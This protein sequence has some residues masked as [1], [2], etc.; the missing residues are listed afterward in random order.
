M[1]KKILVLG[2]G[3]ILF[4]DE[5][6]GVRVVE[7]MQSECT[8]SSNV[9][10]MDGGTLGTKLLD[11]F[12]HCDFLIIVDAVLGP[13]KPGSV[14]RLTGEDLRRSLAFKNS[15]HQTD[16]EDTLLYCELIAKRPDTVVIGVEPADMETA[17]ME[18]SPALNSAMRE[19]VNKTIKEIQACG[20]E[21]NFKKEA[22]F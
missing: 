19:I 11:Y 2:A 7:K 16:L 20:G 14:Y 22:V 18:L 9:T 3:N 13:G 5:G 1:E 10:L 6:V 15:L 12:I 21:C 17:G 8:V 4:T